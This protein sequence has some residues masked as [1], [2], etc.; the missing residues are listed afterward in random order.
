MQIKDK[1]EKKKNSEKLDRKIYSFKMETEKYGSVIYQW[2]SK[3]KDKKLSFPNKLIS[4]F[5]QKF[6]SDSKEKNE[7]L[8]EKSELYSN[9]EKFL[10]NNITYLNFLQLLN[11][12]ENLKKLI[13]NEEQL[14]LFSLLK[15]QDLSQTP[16]ELFHFSN[17]TSDNITFQRVK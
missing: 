4:W 2:R 8:Q 3:K 11:E 16:N 5:K 10:E 7:E 12:V 14:F 15:K 9:A 1:I 17:Q 6:F 13:L